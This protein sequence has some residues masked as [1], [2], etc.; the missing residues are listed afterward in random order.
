MSVTA[1]TPEKESEAYQYKGESKPT[2]CAGCGDY[3]VLA[4]L[5]R[6]LIEI[7]RPPWEIVVVSGIG[8]SSR[9]PYFMNTYGFHSAHGRGLAVATGLKSA[10]PDLLVVATGGD[11]DALAIGGNHFFHTMRRNVDITYL[12]MDNQIY[13]MTKGQT[14]PTSHHGFCT[15]STPYGAIEPPVDPVWSAL[16]MGATFVAQGAS[17]EVKALADLV[18]AGI[19]HKGMAM[20]NILSPCTTYNKEIGKDYFKDHSFPVPADHDPSDLMAA[21]KLARDSSIA[22]RYPLGLLHVRNQPTYGDGLDAAREISRAKGK[23]NSLQ[24]IA[25]HFM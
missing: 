8:C 11:G 14:A 16:T 23:G 24:E 20:I 5:N 25:R 22:D 4:A 19:R 17:F 18:L 13:G 1:E 7:G 9:F 6:A 3:S 12:L 2:W 21:L 10:R 15:K